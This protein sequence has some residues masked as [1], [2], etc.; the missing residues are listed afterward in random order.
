MKATV[1][2][3]LKTGMIMYGK[4]SKQQWSLSNPGQVV[5]T[6]V[7]DFAILCMCV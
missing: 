3:L 7:S 4:E 1:Q 2:D 5:L 6:V